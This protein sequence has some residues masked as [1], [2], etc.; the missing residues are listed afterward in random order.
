MGRIIAFLLSFVLVAYAVW[1]Y[2]GILRI[3]QALSEPDPQAIAPFVDLPA[4]RDAFKQRLAD[5]ITTEMP[6]GEGTDPL[7]GL[8]ARGVRQI[9]DSLIE[10]SL[11]LSGVQTLL[12]SAA[13]RATDRRP[14][15]FIAGIRYAFFESW[16]RF[17]IRLGDGEDATQIIMSLRAL[18]RR[19]TDIGRRPGSP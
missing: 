12:R 1:P 17:A 9:S 18:E 13:A 2:Y 14:A 16:N 19:I 15:Y 6:R 5:G 10:H 8:I 4:I 11:D 3:D 7:V